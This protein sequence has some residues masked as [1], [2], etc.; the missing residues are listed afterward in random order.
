MSKKRK[1]GKKLKE[2]VT[3]TAD[4][5]N[6]NIDTAFAV[7]RVIGERINE[8]TG[9]KYYRL[10]WQGYGSE[11][12]SWEPE[13]NVDCSELIEEFYGRI[14]RSS[15]APKK[16]SIKVR[17]RRSGHIIEYLELKDDV[18]D[19]SLGDK[20]DTPITTPKAADS[21]EANI[22]TLTPKTKACTLPATVD[23][24]VSRK[25]KKL[26]LC[27]CVNSVLDVKDSVTAAS[28]CTCTPSAKKNANGTENKSLLL[29][30]RH[31]SPPPFKSVETPEQNVKESNENLQ[32]EKDF[33]HEASTSDPSVK[34]S[35]FSANSGNETVSIAKTIESRENDNASA[36]NCVKEDFL[37]D[38][39]DSDDDD[40]NSIENRR[41]PQPGFSFMELGAIPHSILAVVEPHDNHPLS[42]VVKYKNKQKVECVPSSLI[43]KMWPQVVIEFY[44]KW[45][46]ESDE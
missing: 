26:K 13:D 9:K 1:S 19:E 43:S 33:L 2:N 24:P 17:T 21:S 16:P 37:K 30:N 39:S 22:S 11:D 46:A 6:F 3:N 7:E 29:E 8:K 41:H 23:T 25:R 28:S 18:I 40:E 44:E 45:L 14:G 36:V 32:R 35:A 4:T 20:D 10:K 42:Y 34:N 38:Y 15:K 5:S 27:E 12:D 31:L